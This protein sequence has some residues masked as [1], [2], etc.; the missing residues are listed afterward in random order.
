M[1]RTVLPLPE[2]LVLLIAALTASAGAGDGPGGGEGSGVI[3]GRLTYAADA[4]RSWRY[5]R[6]YVDQD[7]GSLAEAV[8][9]LSGSRLKNWPSADEPQ[10]AEMDQL[11]YQFVPETLAIRRGDRVRFTNSDSTTHNVMTAS[12]IG[13]FNISME[14]E[15]DY[16]H[17]FDRAGG[18]RRPVQ[19]GCVY[20][21]GMRAW[22]Y[23][24]DHPFF[25]VTEP[26]GAFRF[27]D[28]PPGTYSLEVIH[29]AGGLRGKQAVAISAGG[30]ETVQIRLS[31][32]NKSL[33]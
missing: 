7:S 3:S 9:A 27:E 20:H 4:G 25:A 11:N 13:T 26:D 18:L 23:V 30:K 32:D 28:V 16:L 1:M 19:L 6:Y 12:P 10:Q 21:G 33:P 15:G 29:P 31:P 5:A 22:I 24:F 8:V 17:Q 2:S 14:S